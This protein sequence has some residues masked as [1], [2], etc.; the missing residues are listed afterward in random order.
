MKMI[1]A[2]SLPVKNNPAICANKL[3]F[4]YKPF[5]ICN[6]GLRPFLKHSS[7]GGINTPPTIKRSKMLIK[8]PFNVGVIGGQVFLQD[9]TKFGTKGIQHGTKSNVQNLACIKLI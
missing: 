9:A 5:Q 1:Q 2:I 8:V 7:S 6:I 3:Y 4:V